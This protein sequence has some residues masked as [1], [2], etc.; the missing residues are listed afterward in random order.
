M[1]DLRPCEPEGAGATVRVMVGEGDARSRTKGCDECGHLNGDD[2][3]FCEG[4]GARL[5]GPG[6]PGSG[7]VATAAD[8]T[9]PA[10]AYVGPD[11]STSADQGRLPWYR[12]PGVVLAIAVGVLLIAGA[13][14]AMVAVRDDDTAV[15]TASTSASTTVTTAAAG[16][17]SSA[18]GTTEATTA[19]APAPAPAPLAAPT[20]TG[21]TPTCDVDSA[22]VPEEPCSITVTWDHPGGADSFYIVADSPSWSD[23]LGNDFADGVG[24][25]ARST[26]LSPFATG[27]EVCVTVTAQRGERAEEF[28][29]SA[30]QCV[31]TGIG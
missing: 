16:A 2:A 13:A 28:A 15:T 9:A 30:Q 1:R 11:P 6:D 23:E 29:E 4:C 27:I 12:R 22:P 26:R 19:P 8:V 17:A 14:W 7:A 25:T 18:E 20:I 3:G 31:S 24:G 21:V 5:A 10:T